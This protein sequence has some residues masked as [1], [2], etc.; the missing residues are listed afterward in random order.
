MSG[1]ADAATEGEIAPKRADGYW[2]RFW[3]W[4]GTSQVQFL[5]GGIMGV[6]AAAIAAINVDLW[7]ILAAELVVLT[8]VPPAVLVSV[9]R[10]MAPKPS[11]TVVIVTAAGAGGT[12]TLATSFPSV[13]LTLS[14]TAFVLGRGIVGQ[15]LFWA[16]VLSFAMLGASSVAGWVAGVATTAAF[17]A[18]VGLIAAARR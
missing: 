13:P 1:A 15:P 2:R 11:P 17:A 4:I 8:G 12:L 5:V 6:T 16:T 10:R 9:I 3:T 14:A 18:G 7:W